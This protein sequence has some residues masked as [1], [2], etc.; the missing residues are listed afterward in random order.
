MNRDRT[1]TAGTRANAIERWKAGLAFLAMI[2]VAGFASFIVAA[3][4]MKIAA[5]LFAAPYLGSVTNIL[6][7]AMVAVFPWFV[8]NRKAARAFT[9][10]LD[11]RR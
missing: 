4:P 2:A 10:V 8:T 1:D 11:D 3:I 9:I 7:L 6:V 5:A